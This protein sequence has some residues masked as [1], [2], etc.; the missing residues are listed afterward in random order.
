[1][2]HNGPRPFLTPDELWDK[3]LEFK[4]QEGYILV[5]DGYDRQDKPRFK[6]VIVN[7]TLSGFNVFCGCKR[8][9][10]NDLPKS[11]DEIKDYISQDM[12]QHWNK[13]V[14]CGD[15]KTAYGIFYGK[16]RFGYT[17]RV[18]QEITHKKPTII[19]E[20]I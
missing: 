18:E 2:G 9:W 4:E 7:M 10:W 19:T 11:H 20:D 1:M 13:G 12:E 17:D 16:N 3:Y 14:S 6:K 5:P 15:I 8:N